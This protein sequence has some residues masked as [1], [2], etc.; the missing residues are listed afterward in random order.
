[1]GL[2]MAAA[3]GKLEACLPP[4]L[5]LAH[6]FMIDQC[7]VFIFLVVHATAESP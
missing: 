4:L 2:C 5:S 1:M 7:L 6:H 3:T